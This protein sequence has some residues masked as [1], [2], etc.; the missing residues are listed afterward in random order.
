MFDRSIVK[1]TGQLWKMGVSTA[2]LALAAGIMFYEVAGGRQAGGIDGLFW[3][4]AMLAI[5]A[6]V[7]QAVAIR[8][9]V[10]GLRWFRAP[11][12]GN[13]HLN[14]LIWLLKQPDCPRCKS[15]GAPSR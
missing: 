5:G 1:K 15:S 2:V 14:W 6:V 12:K 7:W 3:G 10:C 13:H 11:V 9:P 8:C 4:A